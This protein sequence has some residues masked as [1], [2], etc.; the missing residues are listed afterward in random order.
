MH[1]YSQPS[2][3]YENDLIIL[4]CGTNDL[5]TNPAKNISDDI[6]SL[7][8]SLKTERN[9]VMIS[10]VIPR[11]DKLND[12]GKEVNRLLSTW[13][14]QNNFNFIDHSNIDIQKHLNYSGI[15]LNFNGTDILGKNLENAIKI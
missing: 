6:I 4:H 12:K 11:R 7:A 15:H 14:F 1:P 9:D 8:K 2:R 13:C 10:G 3:E 5:K